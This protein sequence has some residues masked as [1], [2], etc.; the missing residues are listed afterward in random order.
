MGNVQ[1]GSRGS[2]RGERGTAGLDKLEENVGLGKDDDA[3]WDRVQQG[4]I[5]CH[6]QFSSPRIS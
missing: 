6:V 3:G 4:G 1:V 5:R 2:S